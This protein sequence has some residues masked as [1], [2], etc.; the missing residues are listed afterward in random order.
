MKCK[1][2]YTSNPVHT[3]HC[4]GTDIAS[5]VRDDEENIHHKTVRSFGEEWTIFHSF[6]ED[7][8]QSIGND[9]FDL[10]DFDTSSFIV[11]DVGCGSGRWSKYLSPRVAWIEAIDPSVAVCAA[12]HTLKYCNNVR[13]SQAGVNNIP[14]P[15]NAFDLV[16]S[17][18]VLHHVPDT[19]GAIVHCYNKVKPGGFFLLYLYYNLDSHSRFYRTLFFITNYLR[20][21]ISKLPLRVKRILCDSIALM[22]YLPLARLAKLISRFSENT[23]KKIP[24]SYYRKTSFYVMRNDAFDRFGTPLEQR[25]S[26]TQIAEMLAKAGFTDIRFSNREPYWHVIARK[27]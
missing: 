25:F 16:F 22:I 24:L 4:N 27:P 2:A 10:L 13:I 6:S 26:K 11:L 14:F 20:L 7:E 15:D 19:A 3:W 9:Y 21:I 1:P 23:A 18:G 8:I 17:L 12:A 5:F